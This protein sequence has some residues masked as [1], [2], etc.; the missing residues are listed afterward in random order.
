MKISVGIVD[1]NKQTLRSLSELINYTG[2]F[3][4][5]LTANNGIDFFEKLLNLSIEELPQV[6]LMDIDMPKMDGI[7]TISKARLKY[8]SI[9]YL[10]LTVFDD[11]EKLFNSI[12]AGANGYLLKDEKISVITQHIKDLVNNESTPMSPSIA[13]K[14]FEMLSRMPSKDT[15]SDQLSDLLSARE[16]EVLKLMID[17]FNYKVIAEK[18]FISPNTVKKHIAHIYEKLHVNSRV[19]IIKMNLL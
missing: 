13:K 1:D 11:E 5:I 3:E 9:K 10:V 7:T 16:I 8:P 19:E 2:E 4:V 12:Q 6:V 18:L 14:T 15:K 17:G